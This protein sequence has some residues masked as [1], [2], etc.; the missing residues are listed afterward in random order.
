MNLESAQAAF[1]LHQ[2]IWDTNFGI[3][4]IWNEFVVTHESG[5]RYVF[6]VREENH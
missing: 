5:V 3:L 2:A 1:P 6:S 4:I